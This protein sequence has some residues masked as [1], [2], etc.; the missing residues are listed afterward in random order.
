MHTFNLHRASVICSRIANAIANA[1]CSVFILA[2]FAVCVAMVLTGCSVGQVKAD[3]EQKVAHDIAVQISPV[4]IPDL[5][6]QIAEA[7]AAT[8]PDTD[9]AECGQVTIQLLQDLANTKQPPGDAHTCSLA[10]E[11]YN[12][13]AG[14]C[15]FGVATSIE[16]QRLAATAPPPA[17]LKLPAYWLKGCAVVMND[18]KISA[19]QFLGKLGIALIPIGGELGVMKDAAALSKAAAALQAA[20]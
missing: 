5:Q 16:A 6:N 3:I 17:P 10:V 2:M 9:G 7:N 1:I 19:A 18:M 12:P 20:H 15:Q 14:K 13:A 11:F 4:A 8:P